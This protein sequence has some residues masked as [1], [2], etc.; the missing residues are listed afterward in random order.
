MS[1]SYRLYLEDIRTSAAKVIRYMHELD[2]SVTMPLVSDE[3]RPP[4]LL[5]LQQRQ[6]SKAHVQYWIGSPKSLLVWLLSF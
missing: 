5:Q 4:K 2:L 1:R 3:K 6:Q